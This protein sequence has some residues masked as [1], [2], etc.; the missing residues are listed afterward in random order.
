[1]L[2]SG[3]QYCQASKAFTAGLRDLGAHAH[4]DPL[5]SVS[6]LLQGWGGA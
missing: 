5:T 2:D 1:M 3:R 6:A 4:G